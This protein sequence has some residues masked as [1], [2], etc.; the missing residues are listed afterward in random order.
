[1]HVNDYMSLAVI[2]RAEESYIHACSLMQE[3]AVD[4]IPVVNESDAVISVFS[5]H[6][7]RLAASR[8]N[9][10]P[11]EASEVASTEPVMI[12]EDAPLAA[13]V[14]AMMAR[15]VEVLVVTDAQDRVVGVLNSRDLQH[16]LLKLLTD[17][18][19]NPGL[20]ESVH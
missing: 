18:D 9:I 2:T 7:A 3:H 17:A 19:Q 4:H 15:R 5:R 13:A 8:F 1:M 20:G 6:D 10:G 14:E 11:I 12:A 16:A